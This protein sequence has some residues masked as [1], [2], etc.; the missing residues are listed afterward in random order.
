MSLRLDGC[1]SA[2]DDVEQQDNESYHKQ[3]VDE[4]TNRVAANHAQQP[5]NQKNHKNCPQHERF[6]LFCTIASL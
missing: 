3:D 2:T 6:L 5:K 1:P 4:T